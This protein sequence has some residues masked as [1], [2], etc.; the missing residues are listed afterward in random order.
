MPVTCKRNVVEKTENTVL[1]VAPPFCVKV[2]IT[3]L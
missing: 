2:L 1:Q 3:R